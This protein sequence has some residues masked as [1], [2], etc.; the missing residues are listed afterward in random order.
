MFFS[1]PE[2]LIRKV[3]CRSRFIKKSQ[4]NFG[5]EKRDDKNSFVKKK[6]EPK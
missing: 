3:I 5:A 1:K 4:N 2:K 6:Q